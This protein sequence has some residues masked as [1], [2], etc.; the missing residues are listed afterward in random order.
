MYLAC[1]RYSRCASTT[2]CPAKEDRTSRRSWRESEKAAVS[3]TSTRFSTARGD[4]GVISRKMGAATGAVLRVRTIDRFHRQQQQQQ[5][6][7]LP[8]LAPATEAANAERA[9]MASTWSASRASFSTRAVA[10]SDP[11]T[12]SVG[13]TAPLPHNLADGG[14]KWRGGVRETVKKVTGLSSQPRGEVE[15]SIEEAGPNGGDGGEGNAVWCP[16]AAVAAACETEP[17]LKRVMRAF[18]ARH[19]DATIM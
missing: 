2:A 3:A 9:G 4:A 17:R 14:E 19:P 18:E 5:Q 13:G 8:L 1:V 6:R 10:D 15:Q 7:L 16:R 11:R 12:S